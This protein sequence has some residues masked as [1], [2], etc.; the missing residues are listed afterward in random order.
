[1][2]KI[3]MMGRIAATACMILLAMVVCFSA[4]ACGVSEYTATMELTDSMSEEDKA[5]YV[6]GTSIKKME[7][8]L[9]VDGD[10]YT[11]VKT[12]YGGEQT[13]ASLIDEAYWYTS[14]QMAFRFE[15]KGAC[16]KDGDKVTLE[17]PTEATKL[18]YYQFDVSAL[19]PSRFPL[20]MTTDDSKDPVAVTASDADMK[21]FNG[22]YLM[23]TDEAA[24]QQVATVDGDTIVSIA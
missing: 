13:D 19:Y 12:S 15:F 11:L 20:S 10:M 18:V 3:K 8:S 22:L 21:Y 14:Y 17:V 4:T 16:S 1:M 6:S 7:T 2:K 5:P 23:N 24:A 9:T